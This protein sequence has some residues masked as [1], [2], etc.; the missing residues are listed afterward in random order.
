MQKIEVQYLLVLFPSYSAKIFCTE[1]VISFF[2]RFLWE[3]V[4]PTVE[5]SVSIFFKVSRASHFFL[6]FSSGAS[7][8]S[9][10]V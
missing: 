7:C 5:F 8:E 6:Q 10:L 4:D 2:L 9:E 3:P 1:E